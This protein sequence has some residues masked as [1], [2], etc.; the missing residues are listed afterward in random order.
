MCKLKTMVKVLIAGRA[1]TD[2][3]YDLAF[4]QIKTNIK[5]SLAN[6]KTCFKFS[7]RE[8]MERFVGKHLEAYFLEFIYVAFCYINMHLFI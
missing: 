4:E 5:E 8:E 7:E 2:V 3:F 6:R 1:L